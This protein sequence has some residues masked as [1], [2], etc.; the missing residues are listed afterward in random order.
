MYHLLNRHTVAQD[1]RD[2]LAAK[3]WVMKYALKDAQGNIYEKSPV[4]MHKRI[5]SEIAR[6]E[7]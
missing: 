5:A 3:V 4:D 6:I 2:E 1:A 7:K